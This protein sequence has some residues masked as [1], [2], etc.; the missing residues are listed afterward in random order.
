MFQDKDMPNWHLLE[1]R[2]GAAREFLKKRA[3]QLGKNLVLVWDFYA[4]AR[5]FF[6]T[7]KPAWVSLVASCFHS[8][9]CQFFNSTFL[10]ASAKLICHIFFV[11]HISHC[12]M[13]WT[14]WTPFMHMTPPYQSAK[15][16]HK[17]SLS[18]IFIHFIH[19]Q[20]LKHEQKL[21]EGMHKTRCFCN[22][23]PGPAI[24]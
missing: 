18:V 22:T 23:A 16:M 12:P 7:E 8:A 11:P 2:R 21:Q 4:I 10:R 6:L 9:G 20:F 14:R 3:L 5:A 19:S 15:N 17:S 24:L 13:N 1:W